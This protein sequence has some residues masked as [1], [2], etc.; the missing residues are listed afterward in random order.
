MNELQK[1]WIIET[2]NKHIVDKLNKRSNIPDLNSCWVWMGARTGGGYG[3]ISLNCIIWKVHILSYTLFK[4]PVQYRML[5]CHE[6]D[7]PPCWNPKHLFLGTNSDN[8]K[9]RYNKNRLRI[10]KQINSID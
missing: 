1:K 3:E 4:G 7:N 6:C 10:I 9:D 2:S 8:Q 5:V